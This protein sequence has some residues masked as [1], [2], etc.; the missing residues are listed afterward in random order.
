MGGGRGGGHRQDH[1]PHRCAAFQKGCQCVLV[2]KLLPRKALFSTLFL[3]II[4]LL[5][6]SSKK[7]GHKSKNVHAKIIIKK[8]IYIFIYFLSRCRFFFFFFFWYLLTSQAASRPDLCCVGGL[9]PSDLAQIQ[10][11]RRG[12][13]KAPW[14]S[15]TY[16]HRPSLFSTVI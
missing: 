15:K 13:H 3:I 2:E 16:Q 1:S 6:W 11:P 5:F 8:I 7:T 9:W 14:W 4:L 10:L 12:T